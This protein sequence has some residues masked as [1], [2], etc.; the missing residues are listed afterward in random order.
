M[1]KED[2]DLFWRT[3]LVASPQTCHLPEV[4]VLYWHSAKEETSNFP[5]TRKEGSQRVHATA[6]VARDLI[7]QV[8]VATRKNIITATLIQNYSPCWQCAEEILKIM[9]LANEK[10][11]KIDISIAFV[12]LNRIRRPSW[13]WRGLVNATHSVTVNE[14]NDNSLALR[15]L[16]E[17]G[18][19]LFTFDPDSW[20]FLYT[21]LGN[22][23]PAES[24]GRFTGGKL[25]L[26]ESRFEEDRLTMTD[27]RQIL[28]G[29]FC[30]F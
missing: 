14:S 24:D 20:K 30:L 3:H 22:G 23:F 26:S 4:T 28:K 12:A 13:V 8:R 19:K 5:W 2:F 18:V 29:L 27:F 10:R 7:T 6:A 11:I 21:F 16:S 15:L 9:A 17:A 25:L 1:S